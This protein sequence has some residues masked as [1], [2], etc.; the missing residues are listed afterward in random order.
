MT[1]PDISIIIPCYNEVENVAPVVDALEKTL[2]GF[3]WEVVFVDDNSPDGTMD[4]VRKLAQTKPHVKGLLR[5][6]QR[7]LSSAVIEGA[8]NA[9]APLIAVM[10]GDLQHD[11]R[12]LPEMAALLQSNQ[13]DVV[14][15][16]RH[17]AGGSNEGLSNGWRRFL[18]NSG[19]W[20]ARYLLDVP[21]TDPMS[22]FFV[23]RRSTFL[24][25]VPFLDG[26]GFKILLDIMIA[27]P[28]RLRV[29]EVPMTFRDRAHGESKLDSG[30]ILAFARMLAKH[31]FH[32]RPVPAY[33][34]AAFI[35]ILL[36]WTVKKLL[37]C[38]KT[39]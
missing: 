28:E 17:V 37:C 6:G 10:D 3:S 33:T 34:I 38:K 9:T 32:R 21:L 31:S 30:V 36:L 2:S 5:I 13:A 29:R 19:I 4:A 12:C 35:G 22:G 23:I 27:L 8:L 7:G 1:A 16:S 24:E 39:A 18:S 15:A 26:T 11:E 14:V 25:R 20:G